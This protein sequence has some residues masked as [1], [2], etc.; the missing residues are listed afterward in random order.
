MSSFF[1]VPD[2]DALARM[3]PPPALQVVERSIGGFGGF[4]VADARGALGCDGSAGLDVEVEQLDEAVV[5]IIYHYH[6][7]QVCRLFDFFQVMFEVGFDFIR[8]SWHKINIGWEYAAKIAIL[9]A[10]VAYA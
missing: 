3:A 6:E 5:V 1:A 9:T 7:M 4:D 10:V 2:I 8:F